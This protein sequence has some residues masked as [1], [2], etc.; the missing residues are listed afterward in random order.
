MKLSLSKVL[1]VAALVLGPI[2]CARAAQDGSP[3]TMLPSILATICSFAYYLHS[4]ELDRLRAEASEVERAV[5]SHLSEFTPETRWR[6]FHSSDK[7]SHIQLSRT[8]E[9]CASATI[10]S[11]RGVVCGT[12]R[13]VQEQLPLA[14][15][16]TSATVRVDSTGPYALAIGVLTERYGLNQDPNRDRD[17]DGD[18][19]RRM[20]FSRY[21]WCYTSNG[22][23]NRA[24]I[25]HEYIVG[26][27]LVDGSVVRLTL[28]HRRVTFNIDG[29]YQFV[30]TLPEQCG[31]ISLGVTM[32]RGGKVTLLP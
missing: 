3:I 29:K 6:E 12:V 31:R 9:G 23:A 26:P 4:P 30:F 16:R 20:E 28:D 22:R 18:W 14:G 8:E 5:A 27:K 17:L 21:A 11:G 25:R 1:V 7:G 19:E 13:T 24:S 2:H 32:C 15:E 10:A